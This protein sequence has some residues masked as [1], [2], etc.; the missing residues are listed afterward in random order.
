MLVKPRVVIYRDM[1][2]ENDLEKIKDVA[3]PHVSAMDHLVLIFSLTIDP[4]PIQ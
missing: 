3:R 2:R 1:V 4:V